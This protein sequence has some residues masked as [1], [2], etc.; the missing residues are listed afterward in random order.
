MDTRIPVDNSE[1]TAFCR[2][3]K[4]R[5]LALFGSVLND[6]YRPDS[7]V[8]VLVTFEPNARIGFLALSAIA[9]ELSEIFHRK[10]DLVPKSSLKPLIRDEVI[11][12][13]E[14]LYAA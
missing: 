1:I 3:W 9:R 7:D 12:Q 4:I 13:A 8:D 6:D 5:E 2:K 14:V 10:V 11:A